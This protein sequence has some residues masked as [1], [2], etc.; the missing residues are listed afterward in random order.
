MRH[1]FLA[2]LLVGCGGTVS[3]QEPTAPPVVSSGDE[4]EEVVTPVDTG[5]DTLPPLMSPPSGGEIIVPLAQGA[6]APFAGILLNAEAAAWLEAE[7]DAVQDRA[8][9][10]VTRRLTQVRL[11]SEAEIERLRLRLRTQEE[12][13]QIEIRAHEEQNQSL[14]RVNEDLRQGPI[15]WWEEAL[16]IGGALVVG[17]VVGFIGGI[18]AN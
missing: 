8:Q 16:W 6:T 11:L 12:I 5:S 13:H 2:L 3:A 7:P 1:V 15:Q 10:W 9:I 4:H 18:V 17:L 14:L